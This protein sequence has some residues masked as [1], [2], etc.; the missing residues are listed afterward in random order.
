LIDPDETQANGASTARINEEKQLLKG[1]YYI[2]LGKPVTGWRPSRLRT[3]YVPLAATFL[4]APA[5]SV[6][7][8]NF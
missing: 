1:E 6:A 7:D 3:S 8:R 4:D 2:R 5:P